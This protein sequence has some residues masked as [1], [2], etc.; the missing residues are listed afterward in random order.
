MAKLNTFTFTGP[1]GA[2]RS[3]TLVNPPAGTTF[4]TFQVL[5]ENVV[6]AMRP[7]ITISSTYSTANNRQKLSALLRVP[8]KPS[9]DTAIQYVSVKTDITLPGESD[10]SNREYCAKMLAAF[11][12]DPQVQ[13]S[14]IDG[15]VA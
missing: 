6:A 1:D 11:I 4:G 15:F 8:Y 9:A 13:Q 14:I 10:D 12:S 5:S 7:Q 3:A 2:Q